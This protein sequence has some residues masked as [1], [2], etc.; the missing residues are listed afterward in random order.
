M[1]GDYIKERVRTIMEEKELPESME[2]KIKRFDGTIIDMEINCSLVN[3]RGKKAIQTVCR[4]I[5]KRKETESTLNKAIVEIHELSAPLVPILDGIAVLPLIGSI[6]SYR[7]TH[8]LETIPSMV[9]KRGVHFLIIDF[10]G[11]HT[12]DTTVTDYLFNIN[13]GASI[14]WCSLYDNGFKT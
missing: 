12:L 2:Q 1:L 9:Q 11:I 6:D 13:C 7:A 4:D 10:S 8:I 14:T 3:Y 5:T